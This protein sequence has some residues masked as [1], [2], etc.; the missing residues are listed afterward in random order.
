M[1]HFKKAIQLGLFVGAARA[2][3]TTEEAVLLRQGLMGPLEDYKAGRCDEEDII[4]LVRQ[5][6]PDGWQPAPEWAEA[7]EDAGFTDKDSGK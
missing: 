5:L 4:D 2:S 7:L 3:C 6:M 1:S